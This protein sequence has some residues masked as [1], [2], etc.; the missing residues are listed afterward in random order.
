M[1]VFNLFFVVRQN[2]DFRYPFEPPSVRFVTPIYHPNIDDGGRICLDTLSTPPKVKAN[3]CCCFSKKKITYIG[4]LD[5]SFEY[6]NSA[7][8]DSNSHT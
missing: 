8:D 2:F 4:L 1:I 6:C 3:L 7:Q 5:A